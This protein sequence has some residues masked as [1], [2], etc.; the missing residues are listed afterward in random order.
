MYLLIYLFQNHN[1]LN[2]VNNNMLAKDDFVGLLNFHCKF[3]N[4]T[5]YNTI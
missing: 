3:I 1:Y 5:S 2:C 4:F